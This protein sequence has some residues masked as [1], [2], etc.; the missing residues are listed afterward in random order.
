VK[1]L[2][3][4]F[5]LSAVI[6]LFAAIVIAQPETKPS[7]AILKVSAT[8]TT[9][10]VTLGKEFP[11]ISG[12]PTGYLFSIDKKGNEVQ[13]T[14]IP[15]TIASPYRTFE[16][17]IPAGAYDPSLSYEVLVFVPSQNESGNGITLKK[18]IKVR[19]LFS[20]AISRQDNCEGLMMVISTPERNK[21]DLWIPV[22]NWLNHFA[23]ENA[24][25]IADVLVTVPG[26]ILNRPNKITALRWTKRDSIQL[27]AGQLRVCVL[28]NDELP[29][30]DFTA[31]FQFHGPDLPPSISTATGE[32]L[33]GSV[34]VDFPPIDKDIAEPSKRKF[35]RNLDLGLTLT[36]EVADKTV[37]A[38]DTTPETVTRERTSRG[39][40]DLRFAPWMDVLHP[41]FKSNRWLHHLTP[42]MIN[43]NVA[44]GKIEKETLGMNRILIGLEGESRYVHRRDFKV[45]L[46]NGNEQ[47]RITYPVWHRVIWGFTHGSDRDFKQKEFVGKIEYK[48]V[49]DK[50]YQPYSLN[51]TIDAN[52]LRKPA[53]WGFTFLPEIG[54]QI[55]RT[56][57]RRNPA[58]AIKP[59]DTVRRLYFGGEISLDI[60]EYVTLSVTDDLYI[61]G[62]NPEDHYKNYFKATGEFRLG[63]SSNG[64]FAH[65]LYA[66]FERGQQ[67][68]FSSPDVN[69]FR[70][71]YRIQGNYCGTHCR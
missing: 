34:A 39:V 61:R 7:K 26:V 14:S 15:N 42:L 52:G 19:G 59:S 13:V 62:E 53:G 3:P 44:T 30:S 8:S 64:L 20:V 67:P 27:G 29:I 32:D 48:P 71:G 16:I 70:I 65:S 60:T 21:P 69:S 33:A 50:L 38:T 36:S 31:A 17:P 4:L 51:Y 47:D 66:V 5:A 11:T 41:P 40:I 18:S 28:F 54:F 12:K 37:A 46:A 24:D 49:F 58:S 68:P 9:V 57:S 35:E 1:K 63:R 2:G 23:G 10:E 55:G 22:Y 43:A 25:D 45:K 56:Y 6:L